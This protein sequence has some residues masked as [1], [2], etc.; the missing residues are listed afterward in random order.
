MAAPVRKQVPY[1]Q[2]ASAR[3]AGDGASHADLPPSLRAL[4]AVV[5]TLKIPPKIFP[6]NLTRIADC[7]KSLATF[8]LLLRRPLR[9]AVAQDTVTHAEEEPLSRG[10][11]GYFCAAAWSRLGGDGELS[12]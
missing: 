5:I 10:G 8:V 1:R 12:P 2:A 7:G 6:E 11:V 9:C 4:H 3:V